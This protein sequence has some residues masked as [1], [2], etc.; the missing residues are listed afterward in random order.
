MDASVFVV[1]VICLID[2]S[3][4][5]QFKNIDVARISN[6]VLLYLKYFTAFSVD[7]K[8]QLESV[9]MAIKSSVGDLSLVYPALS[10][11]RTS[12]TRTS[13]EKFFITVESYKK[14][15]ATPS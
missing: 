4:I 13:E 12:S 14:S 7:L 2:L 11:L 8:E 15:S 3:A 9:I 5:K 6:Y 1:P 10:K